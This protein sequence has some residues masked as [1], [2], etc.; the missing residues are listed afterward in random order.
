MSGT[1]YPKNPMGQTL[2]KVKGEWSAFGHAF[3]DYMI[4]GGCGI[5][6]D[7]HQRKPAIC[8]NPKGEAVRRQ[9]EAA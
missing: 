7:D 5:S 2:K 9:K 4:C 8:A 1:T 3:N 6:F